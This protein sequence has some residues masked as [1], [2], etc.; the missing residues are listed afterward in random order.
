MEAIRT[1]RTKFPE[2][3][4]KQGKLVIVFFPQNLL[5]VGT[6]QRLRTRVWYNFRAT[7][8]K[9]KNKQNLAITEATVAKLER[10]LGP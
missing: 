8:G 6:G 7:D 4:Q 5:S 2:K 10:L 9:K 3:G 1:R